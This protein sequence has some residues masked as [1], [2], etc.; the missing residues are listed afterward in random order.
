MSELEQTLKDLKKT[1]NLQR[2][3][4]RG[5]VDPEA[6]ARSII[7]LANVIKDFKQRI[8]DDLDRFRSD[9]RSQTQTVQAA[10]KDAKSTLTAVGH[11]ASSV[12]RE[13]DAMK[14]SIPT[15]FDSSKI[16]DAIEQLRLAIP[17]IPEI[18]P[19]FDPSSII[20]TQEHLKKAIDELND[21]IEQVR[22]I[23]VAT[24]KSGGGMN[25]AHISDLDISSQLDGSTKTFNIPAVFS[26][27]TV[28]LSSFPT[29]LRKNIDY[30]YTN[31]TITFSDEIDA[32]SS[33]AE[34]QTCVL[35]VVN[36]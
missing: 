35:T 15:A 12:R 23:K 25:R 5:G 30:T 31:T 18:P 21:R 13:L 9:F 7:A 2:L 36:A 34:G 6:V 29:V 24:S 27:I 8:E 22:K 17:E 1:R 14:Q 32:A 16:E 10:Q 33:L 26:I 19:A 11:V 20:D 3:M 4:E 28:S